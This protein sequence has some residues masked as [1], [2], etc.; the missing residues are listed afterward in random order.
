MVRN[1]WVFHISPEAN[2]M[3]EVFHIPS[4]F[5]TLS[6]ALLDKWLYAVFFDLVFPSRPSFSLNFQLYRQSVGIP[7]CFSR[8]LIAFHSTVSQDH[9]LD[10]IGSLRGRCA[11]FRLRS[12]VR[13]RIRR[14]DFLHALSYFLEDLIVF[15]ELLNP[16][17]L[18]RQSSCRLKLSCTCL[19][20]LKLKFLVLFVR[21]KDKK[22]LPPCNRTKA[23]LIVTTCY[24][25]SYAFP[26]TGN[27][28]QLLT[29]ALPAFYILCAGYADSELQLG[30]DISPAATC[31]G[32]PPSRLAFHRP[33]TRRLLSSSSFSCLIITRGCKRCQEWK[34]YFIGSFPRFYGIFGGVRCYLDGEW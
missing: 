6:L 28:R 27:G 11:V 24:I 1:V 3:G 20:L 9:I 25:L 26:V 22:K 34:A 33:F 12:A 4:Y 21:V 32:L 5:H 19:Y 31:T 2:G 15:P 29:T 10:N 30:S 14:T 17:F 23:V 16:V 7:A 8:Y 13:H 18:S